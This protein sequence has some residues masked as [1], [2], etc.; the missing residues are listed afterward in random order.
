MKPCLGDVVLNRYALISPLRNDE[1]LQV[2]Q[3][4]DNI[5]ARDCQLFIVRDSRF[6][7]E[8]NTISSTL[9]LARSSKFTQVLQL[10]HIDDVAII[11]TAL[12]SGLSISD[13]LSDN[14]KQKKK[15]QLNPLSYEAIRTIVSET[16]SIVSKMIANGITHHAISTDTVRLTARGIELA[17]TPVSPMIKDVTLLQNK[18]DSADDNKSNSAE[19]IQTP[20]PEF[21]EQV[22]TR[23]LAALLYALLTRTKSQNLQD[24]SMSRLPEN[25]PSEFR[26]I[27]K[28]GLAKVNNQNNSQADSKVIPMASI[29]ELSA[30]LGTYTQLRN[31][32][33]Q[34]ILL[35]RLEGEASINSVQLKP[36]DEKTILPFPEGLSQN[37]DE[38]DSALEQAE[39]SGLLNE[40]FAI[41]S[42]G[43]YEN[44]KD[45][46]SMLVNSNDSDNKS[47]NS[48]S[49]GNA[50]KSSSKK[51]FLGV[52]IANGVNSAASSVTS[53]KASEIES[54]ASASNAA[55][56]I[57]SAAVS[58]AGTGLRKAGKTI[59]TLFRRNSHKKSEK[60]SDNFET[61]NSYEVGVDT[62]STGSFDVDFHDIAAAEM[63]SIL[64]PTELD[65]DDSLFPLSEQRTQIIKEDYRKLAKKSSET[66][67][68]ESSDSNADNSYSVENPINKNSNNGVDEN[69]SNDSNYSNDASAS[70]D[71]GNSGNSGNSTEGNENTD[72]DHISTVAS[73]VFDFSDLLTENAHHT[74]PLSRV[75]ALIG[76]ETELTGRV[77]VVDN[78]SHF[79]APGEESARALREESLEDTDTDLHTVSS[80]SS[81]PPSFEPREH[82][83]SL[84]KQNQ[85]RKNAND[86]AD[87]KIFGGLS[88]KVIAIGA[89]VIILVAG[90]FLALHGLLNHGDSSS[91]FIDA[92][93][94]DSKNINS[95]PFG[96]RGI[97]PE[98]KA[99]GRKVPEGRKYAKA[100]PAPAIPV[101]KTAYEVDIRQFLNKPSNMDGYGY[102]M[103][104]TQPQLAYKFVIS[105]R[106]SGGRGYLFANTKDDPNSGDKLAEF[107]FDESG[108]TEVKFTHPVKSQ[109]F[110][111]WVPRESM[112]NN[113]LYINYA[114]IY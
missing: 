109:D 63:A 30:L 37:E 80:F 100:V 35:P 14:F 20:S 42:I 107:T 6:L 55:S 8:I 34:D 79:I 25:I 43:S 59:G 48:S 111:L 89:M 7:P 61:Q 86:I 69:N 76:E 88:T 56:S 38:L 72:L 9:A 17:D 11:I 85:L 49:K 102:Y 15:V 65:A 23:Q 32:S 81:L 71:S 68:D 22:A 67:D 101:N 62:T 13:Y 19:N 94:W 90:S 27:C 104:L 12:D 28:R 54:D 64:A 103:H 21:Y 110:L 95:V 36:S 57:H 24:F 82:T 93:P 39:N 44:A 47:D 4:S 33:A 78:Q 66:V 108:K 40:N 70:S 105:I 99:K 83:A 75:N 91:S 45:I 5:L 60:S 50:G 84:N 1:E 3:T 31:L 46:P 18:S 2:W 112:P 51:G 74:E 16:A 41:E 96:S 114:K 106:S 98:E 113:S 73:N 92:N 77:P 29:A 10:Q 52:S 53:A 87:A 58:A 26:M 97:L